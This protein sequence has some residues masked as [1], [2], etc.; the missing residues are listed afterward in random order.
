M[1]KNLAFL[2]MIVTAPTFAMDS[3]IKVIK[4]GIVVVGPD[5]SLAGKY[6]AVA[7]CHTPIHHLM[8]PTIYHLKPLD[9]G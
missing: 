7:S 1:K 2:L 3:E 5:H 8:G 4:N 9:F 6:R